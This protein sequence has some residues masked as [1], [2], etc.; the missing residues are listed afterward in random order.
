[1][2]EC[3]YVSARG[4]LETSV[5]YDSIII[6]SLRM[7]FCFKAKRNPVQVL[8]SDVCCWK[9]NETEKR[10]G[11]ACRCPEFAYRWLLF[12][13]YKRLSCEHTPIKDCW[14]CLI[15]TRKMKY[16]KYHTK[17]MKFLRHMTHESA[18]E[19][20][21]GEARGSKKKKKVIEVLQAHKTV[22]IRLF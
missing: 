18:L 22:I 11:D 4:S 7:H 19:K 21:D 8:L 2:W 15:Q 20:Y 14:C 3:T 12:L 5:W 9:M 17:Y 10:R 16:G 6:S 1:M 13:K